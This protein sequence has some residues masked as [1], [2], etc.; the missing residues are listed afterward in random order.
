MEINSQSSFN[1]ELVIGDILALNT[2]LSDIYK[3]DNTT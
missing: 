1:L 2:I 3:A